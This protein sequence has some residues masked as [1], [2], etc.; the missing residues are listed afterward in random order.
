MVDD[1][2]S[3][4]EII[5][6]EIEQTLKKIERCGDYIQSVGAQ[7]T[8]TPWEMRVNIPGKMW[9]ISCRQTIDTKLWPNIDTLD[10]LFTELQEKQKERIS[11]WPKLPEAM[12]KHMDDPRS[13]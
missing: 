3:K 5:D 9:P 8:K 4:Y 1:I 11:L 12:R 13:I 10:K 6:K 7:I 2:I